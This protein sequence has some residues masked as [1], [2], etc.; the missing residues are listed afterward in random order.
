MKAATYRVLRNSEN[1]VTL[2]IA[3]DGILLSPMTDKIA[4][5]W[6]KLHDV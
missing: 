1:T 4:I 3:Y 5:S 2:V 6:F